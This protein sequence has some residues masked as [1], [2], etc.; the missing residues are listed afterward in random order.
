[1]ETS[2]DLLVE[3]PHRFIHTFI[4]CFLISFFGARTIDEAGSHL[5]SA[6]EPLLSVAYTKARTSQEAWPSVPLRVNHWRAG[7]QQR[8]G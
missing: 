3:V 5:N 8:W 4:L 1:M 7:Q 6:F 2:F